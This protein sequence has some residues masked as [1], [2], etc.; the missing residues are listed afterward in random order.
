MG[1]EQSNPE[2]EK[3]IKEQ[4][5]NLSSGSML[6]EV[7]LRGK[8]VRACSPRLISRMRKYKT[9]LL[10]SLDHRAQE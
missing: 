5:G 2:W 4:E 10:D 9:G 3:K 7:K 6:R 1:I 8:K